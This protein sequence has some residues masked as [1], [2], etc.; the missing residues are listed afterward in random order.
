MGRKHWNELP[1]GTDSRLGQDEQLRHLDAPELVERAEVVLGDLDDL[2]VLL[3]FSVFEAIVRERVLADVEADLPTIHHIAL[4]SAVEH[5]K[6][7][8]RN[9][10]FYNHVL[11]HCK[12][13]GPDLVEE[14]NQVRKYRNWVAHGRR[15]VQPDSVDPAIARNR[16]QRFLELL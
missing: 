10:S 11:V 12:G 1:W 2:C 16:L 8:I 9:S 4:K 15:G 5:M 3:L 13:V 14:V 7:D 6:E